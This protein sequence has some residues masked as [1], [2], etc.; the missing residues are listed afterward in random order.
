VFMVIRIDN[1]NR[2]T[3]FNNEANKMIIRR[4]T[5]E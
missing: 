4:V 3:A 5:R 1:T 2:E